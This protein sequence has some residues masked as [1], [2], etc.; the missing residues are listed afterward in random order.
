MLSL[1][2]LQVFD[3]EVIKNVIVSVAPNLSSEFLTRNNFDD[4]ISNIR[5][6][7]TDDYDQ[8]FNW[9]LEL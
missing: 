6:Q 9:S 8:E 7:Y 2:I 3:C 1:P 5:C 4:I